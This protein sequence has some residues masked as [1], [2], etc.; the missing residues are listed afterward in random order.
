MSRP[1][2]H[3]CLTGNEDIYVVGA[4]IEMYPDLNAVC[5][6]LLPEDARREFSGTRNADGTSRDVKPELSDKE[7]RE[8]T[9]RTWKELYEKNRQEQKKKADNTRTKSIEE[10]TKTSIESALSSLVPHLG[11]S[12]SGGS[13]W[14]EHTEKLESQAALLDLNA[15]I[16]EEYKSFSGE[17]ERLVEAR[18]EG[19]GPVSVRETFVKAMVAQVEQRML[20]ASSVIV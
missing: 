3:V 15:K 9:K 10:I 12:A 20:K 5:S 14:R 13:K 19:D 4:T 17:L 1:I 11:A 8:N 18:G 7:G 16:N 6:N 2:I